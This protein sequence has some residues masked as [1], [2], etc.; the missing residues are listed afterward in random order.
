MTKA[1]QAQYP[2]RGEIWYFQGLSAVQ[3]GVV[4]SE[5]ARNQQADDVLIV[6]LTS[7]SNPASQPASQS[8]TT[9][10]QP[11]ISSAVSGLPE[12]VR[13]N[14][15]DITRVEKLDLQQGPVGTLP[16]TSLAQIVRAIRSAIGDALVHPVH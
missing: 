13:A 7:A 3:L 6:P 12:D 10:G 1:S 16:E 11:L 5:C 8:V 15:A 2:R 9:Q 14:C 4:L